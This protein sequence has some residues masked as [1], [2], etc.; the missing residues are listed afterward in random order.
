METNDLTGKVALVT[1]SGR[2]L[3]HTMATQLAAQG[4]IVAIHDISREAP[5]EFG[6]HADL[7]ASAVAAGAKLGV[8]GDVSNLADVTRFIRE[9]EDKLG[10]I[11]IL[12]NAAG[13]DIAAAGGKPKPN[14]A[15]GVKLEDIQAMLSRNLV[16]TILLCQA[17]GNQMAERKGG[18]IVN[19]A[20]IAAHVGRD[21][22]VIYAVA[23]AGIVEY[24]RCLAYQLRPHNVRVNAIS[25]GPTRTARFDATRPL[26]PAMTITEGTLD[27]YGLPEEVAD[28]VIF[29]CSPAARF[30]SG[31]VLRV[32]GGLQLFAA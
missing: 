2:G 21:D 25:P 12:V 3:G 29:L 5:A 22:G 13:G 19:I 8:I 18:A 30:I 16:G 4:A 9:I 32:D 17:V 27:R 28:G 6:E 1:G 26:D 10:P 20:S 7:D 24:T 11:E 15:L 14:D 31:Q 23:K